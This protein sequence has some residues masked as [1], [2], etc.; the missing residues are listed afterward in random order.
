MR[1]PN[2][3]SAR[4]IETVQGEE[5]DWLGVGRASVVEPLAPCSV[6]LA[7]RIFASRKDS[8]RKRWYRARFEEGP[9]LDPSRSA[10]ETRPRGRESPGP[11]PSRARRG[12]AEMKQDISLASALASFSSTSNSVAATPRCVTYPDPKPS[13]ALDRPRSDDSF[14]PLR[15]RD[16]RGHSIPHI[17]LARR[18]ATA[19]PTQ[20]TPR[21]R[22]SP[23]EAARWPGRRP[24]PARRTRREP[25]AVPDPPPSA[26]GPG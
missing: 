4:V 26:G 12:A 9:A 14:A 1:A 10:H 20:S 21:T 19:R 18:R 6:V 5:T 13:Q 15:Q 7:S 11:N 17:S 3:Y 2:E 23:R 8:T 24:A 25:A 16:A 22:T